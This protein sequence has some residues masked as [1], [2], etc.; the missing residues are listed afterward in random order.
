M[1]RGTVDDY[2]VVV[3]GAA[4]PTDTDH[5][6]GARLDAFRAWAAETDAELVGVEERQTGS[7]VDEPYQVTT[8]PVLA[9]AEYHD[10]DLVAVTPSE[11]NGAIRTVAD[12]VGALQ[13]ANPPVEQ[14]LTA[15]D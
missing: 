4:I 15:S 14:P 2:E 11:Q 5:E 13:E 7:L 10:G 9:V 6:L 12:H 8:L 3:W 1:E